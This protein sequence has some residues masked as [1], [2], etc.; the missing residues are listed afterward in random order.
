MVKFFIRLL[1][2]AFVLWLTFQIVP[3]LSAETATIWTWLIVAI[4]FG[5]VNAL[6]RPIVLFLSCPLVILTLGL[7]V[8]VVNTIMLSLTIWLSSLLNLGLS[9]DG[10]WSTF[11]GAI[12]ISVVSWLVSLILPDDRDQ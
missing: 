10:F 7:F 2:N 5:V 12:V 6:I 3:G 11:I 8:L 1:I 9:S 4:I